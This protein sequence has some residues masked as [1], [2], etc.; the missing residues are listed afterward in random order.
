MNMNRQNTLKT[1]LVLTILVMMTACGQAKDDSSGDLASRATTATPTA[2]ATTKT[3]AYCNQRTKS[4]LAAN[5][6]VYADST[7]AVR[8]DYMKVKFTAVPADFASGSYIEFFRWQANT[9]GTTYLDPTPTQARI[10][11][12]SGQILIPFSP[13]IYWGQLSQLAANAGISDPSTFMQQIRL[14]VDTRDPQGQYDV[15][16][17]AYYN[18]S[19]AA[20]IN[21]D[22]LMPLFSASPKDYQNDGGG[23]R[24]SILQGLHPFAAKINDGTTAAQFQT[25]ANAFCF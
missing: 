19:N 25:L 1:V 12:A 7:G 6:M 22:M 20:I 10:E 16:K 14:V 4:G 2:T 9:S 24:A 13:V 11:T 23:V 21:M 15:L 17:I 18:S 8:N 3:Y 5:L